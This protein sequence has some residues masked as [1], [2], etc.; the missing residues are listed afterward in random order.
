MQDSMPSLR[1]SFWLHAALPRAAALAAV[2]ALGQLP[3]QP[4]ALLGG[5]LACDLLLFGWQF[6]H[7]QRSADSHVRHHGGLA[8]VWGG[9]LAFLFAA[10][11]AASLW[12]G[13]F[14]NAPVPEHPELFTERMDR[15]HASAYRLEVRPGGHEI[16]FEGVITFGLAERLTGILRRNP[17]AGVLV[18][19]SEGGHIYEARGAARAILAHGLA[20]R[21]AGTCAS[22]CTLMFAAGNPRSMAP[23]AQL[24]FHGY[25]LEGGGGL[26]HI[27]IAGEQAKDRDFLR[28]R[29]AQEDFLGQAFS[30][31]QSSLWTL[32]EPAAR[33]AGLL[34]P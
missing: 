19:T 2:W 30:T 4:A 28:S 6:R 31:P 32:D 21:A 23:G 24:G 12:W 10:C 18:L 15:E 33:A 7:F 11:A 13:V 9:Q 14:L 25:G 26:P 20:T 5:F 8:P 34:T 1:R 22:A 17:A 3:P 27:D 29:G 16:H